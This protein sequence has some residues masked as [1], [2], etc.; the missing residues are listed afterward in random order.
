MSL[1]L[2]KLKKCN[3]ISDF[4]R[5]FNLGLSAK[6]VG[7]IIYGL[8]DHKKYDSFEILKSNGGLRTIHAPKN[9]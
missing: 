9:H 3:S 6:Q 1:H 5:E 2:E 7:Y 8:P 4:I